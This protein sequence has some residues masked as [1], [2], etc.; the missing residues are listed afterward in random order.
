MNARRLLHESVHA[1]SPVAGVH[2]AVGVEKFRISLLA[3][4]PV[5][6]SFICLLYFHYYSWADTI[7]IAQLE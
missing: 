7:L 3:S 2:S 6:P 4:R 5:V 1:I